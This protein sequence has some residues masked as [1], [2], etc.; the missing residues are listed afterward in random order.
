MT[1]QNS[2]KNKTNDIVFI[3][4]FAVL[5]VVCSWIS[6]PSVV[7]FTM[8]TFAVYLTLN[9]LG[10]K[11][12]TVSIFIYL[13]LGLIGAPVFSN[14]NSG[15]GALF[16][17]TGGYMLGWLLSGLVMGLLE[18]LIGTKIWAQA[19]SML[20]GLIV[21]YIVGTAWFMVVYARNTGPI[22]IWSALLWCVIPFI[23]P[24]LLKLGLALW[25]SL[26]LKKITKLV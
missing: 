6:I 26:R 3:A 22:G 9:Y 7:P 13:C 4:L 5:I 25:I 2:N 8:Q 14:F 24:D 23:I 15:I 18:K 17:V 11:R 1:P 19:I 10:A 20:A 21:C 16:G 12:G